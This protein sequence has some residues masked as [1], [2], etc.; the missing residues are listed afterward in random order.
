MIYGAD[1]PTGGQAGIRWASKVATCNSP[2]NACLFPGCGRL[3]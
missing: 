2:A 1:P 3:L